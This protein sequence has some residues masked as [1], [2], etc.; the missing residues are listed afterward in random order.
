ML[1]FLSK[2]INGGPTRRLPHLRTGSFD[3]LALVPLPL[4]VRLARGTGRA[5]SGIATVAT[6]TTHAD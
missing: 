5:C 6:S 4:T 1:V 3:L 2:W